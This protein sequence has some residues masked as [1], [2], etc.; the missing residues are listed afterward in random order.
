MTSEAQKR[1]IAKY[2]SSKARVAIRFT[3]DEK[4]E[5]EQAAAAAGMSVN[6]Y[7][8]ALILKK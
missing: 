1:A 6:E 8:K 4:K 5:V 3:P 2:E 7:C